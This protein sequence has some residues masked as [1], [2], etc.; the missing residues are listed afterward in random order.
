MYIDKN[1]YTYTL[2]D[3]ALSCRW[4]PGSEGSEGTWTQ[5]T[6]L[7]KRKR[8]EKAK[9]PPAA[10]MVQPK[11][12]HVDKVCVRV[13]VHHRRRVTQA[14]MACV[15]RFELC[16]FY[17]AVRRALRFVHQNCNKVA[18]VGLCSENTF[19]MLYPFIF[20]GIY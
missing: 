5:R 17:A 11:P 9:A 4:L 7:L 19:S 6:V 13:H 10:T 18:K 15:G 3:C 16:V 2:Y 8:V 12:F 1:I 20:V 14:C